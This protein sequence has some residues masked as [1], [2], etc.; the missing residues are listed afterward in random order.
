MAGDRW[1]GQAAGCEVGACGCEEALGAHGP[2]NLDAGVAVRSDRV[3]SRCPMSWPQLALPV[4]YGAA[5]A[6]DLF[7]ILHEVG[8]KPANSIWLRVERRATCF[9]R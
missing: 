6:S 1:A 9:V 7:S 3:L 5:K 8:P 2:A 4:N